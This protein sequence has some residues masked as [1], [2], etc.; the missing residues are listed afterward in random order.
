MRFFLDENF[1]RAAADLLT[2]AGHDCSRAL[3]HFPAG[4]RDNV[5]FAK[6]QELNA[7]FITTDRDFFHTVPW[8]HAR[9]AGVI[10]I[11]LAQPNR[12]ALLARLQDALGLLQGR[13]PF[14]RVWLLTDDRLFER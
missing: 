1:P 8:L 7:I 5:L 14:H 10:A 12:T 3:E 9:H 4:A 6:A 2:S 11:T 13:E